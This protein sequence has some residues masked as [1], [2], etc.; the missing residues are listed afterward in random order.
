MTIEP[1]GYFRAEPFGWTDCHDDDDG[2]IPLWDNAALLAIEKQR[3]ELLSALE[4]ACKCIG[5]GAFDNAK[6]VYLSETGNKTAW[7]MLKFRRW[8]KDK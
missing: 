7:S 3:D 6:L 4:D 2:A 1:F 8:L 5:F